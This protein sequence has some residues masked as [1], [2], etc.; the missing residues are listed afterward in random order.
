MGSA[1][2]EKLQGQ[3][4]LSWDWVCF[5]TESRLTD[6]HMDYDRINHCRVTTIVNKK[7]DIY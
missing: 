4:V 5:K 6:G 2:R 1:G 3:A 7:N